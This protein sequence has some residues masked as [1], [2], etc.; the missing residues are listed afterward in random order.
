MDEDDEVQPEESNETEWKPSMNLY[1]LIQY[2]P[3][4]IAETIQSLSMQS[5]SGQALPMI[6]NFYLGLSYDYQ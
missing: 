5:S 2:I 6:G 4:F 3:D 1:E